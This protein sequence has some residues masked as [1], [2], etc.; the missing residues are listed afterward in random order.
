M[1]RVENLYASYGKGDVLRGINLELNKGET[2]AILGPNGAGKTTL[3][4]A[5]CGLVR[6]RGR[7]FFNGTEIS[8]L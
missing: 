6:T 7:I 4:K 3:L 8:R 2:V 1:L 5:I